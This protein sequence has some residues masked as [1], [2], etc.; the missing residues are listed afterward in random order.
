MCLAFEQTRKG[1]AAFAHVL[2]ELHHY[3]LICRYLRAQCMIFLLNRRDESGRL[4]SFIAKDISVRLG[5][6]RRTIDHMHQ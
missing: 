3:Q 1:L 2:L 6:H 5:A 4:V